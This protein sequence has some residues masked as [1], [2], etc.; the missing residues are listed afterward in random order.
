VATQAVLDSIQE[1]LRHPLDR[2]WSI[3]GLGMLRTYLDPERVHRLHV[4][5][6]QS[7]VHEVSTIH[8]HPWDFVSNIISGQLVNQR[9]LIGTADDEVSEPFHH[10]Q[11]LC[12]E[13]G[14]LFGETDTAWLSPQPLETY[15]PGDAYSQV[16]AELHESRPTPGAVTIISRTFH[17][18]VDHANVY[19]EQGE[20]VSA[21]PRPATDDEVLRFTYLA[22]QHW[23][24]HR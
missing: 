23:N 1:T 24:E 14:G 21:E 17:E 7:A 18:N 20:W 10:S 9:F 3:Q 6:P 15:L 5:D 8:D 2:E 13:G 4:W 19:W 11:I 12:G 16:A 22:L